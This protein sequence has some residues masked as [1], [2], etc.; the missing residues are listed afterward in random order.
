MPR[1]VRFSSGYE[2]CSDAD[3][4]V[5]PLAPRRILRRLNWPGPIAPYCKDPRCANNEDQ[6][7]FVFVVGTCAIAAQITLECV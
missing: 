3:A 6:A 4:E 7:A 1:P 2:V 5:M